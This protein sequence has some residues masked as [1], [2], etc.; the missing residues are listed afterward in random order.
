MCM[1]ACNFQ[2]KAGEGGKEGETQD[3][4]IQVLPSYHPTEPRSFLPPPYHPFHLVVGMGALSNQPSVL[5][6]KNRVVKGETQDSCV[7]L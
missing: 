3:A 4:V 2:G 6:V 1:G 5:Q 7:L